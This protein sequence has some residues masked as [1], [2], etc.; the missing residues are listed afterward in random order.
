MNLYLVKN[1]VTGEYL[2]YDNEMGA[3]W[4]ELEFATFF[5]RRD[6]AE[7]HA[8]NFN[9]QEPDGCVVEPWHAFKDHARYEDYPPAMAIV[10]GYDWEGLYHDGELVEQGHELNA[11]QALTAC[12]YTVVMRPMSDEWMQAGGLP[13]HL[14]DVKE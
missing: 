9:R 12:G 2:E 3:E 8:K 1:T 4:R 13:K 5:H 7:Y 14:E 6:E 10:Y 11:Y